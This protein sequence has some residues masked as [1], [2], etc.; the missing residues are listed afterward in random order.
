MTGNTMSKHNHHRHPWI[1]EFAFRFTNDHQRN[2]VE[3]LGILA[4][5]VVRV[6]LGAVIPGAVVLEPHGTQVRTVACPSRQAARR[7]CRTFGGR[8]DSRRQDA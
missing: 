4:H 3:E 7:L 8:I 6:W 5:D 2:V 1:V